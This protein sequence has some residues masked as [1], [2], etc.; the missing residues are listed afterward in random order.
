MNEPLTLKRREL[1]LGALVGALGAAVGCGS[2]DGVDSELDSGV[3]SGVDT[4]AGSADAWAT[5]G[6]AGM[7]A[8]YA[9][10]FSDDC[11]QTC[12]LTLGPCYAETLTREDISEG[13]DGLPTR[14]VFRVVDTDCNPVEGAVVDVWHCAPSG[15]YSGDDAADMC[16]EGDAEATSSRWFRGQQSTDADGRVDFNTC[17]PGWYPSRAVHIHF[18]VLLNGAA[19]VVS[20]LGFDEDLLED[21]FDVHPVY[22]PYGQP[23]T[24]N[25]QDNIL[26]RDLD[27]SLFEWKRA[28][29]GVLVVW[30]T[31]VIR[32]SLSEST[33]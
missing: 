4:G 23:D 25:S 27:R 22:S 20:Q 11:A 15:L 17:M 21:V 33:C 8:T 29:D 19:Y 18:Q 5:G 28:S 16:T 31:L 30:K 9:V 3:D 7:A 2:K 13:E 24:P 12:E 14:L 32:R 1:L 6:T 10:S 26:G